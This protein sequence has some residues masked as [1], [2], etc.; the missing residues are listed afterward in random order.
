MLRDEHP[1]GEKFFE[2]KPRLVPMKEQDPEALPEFPRLRGPLDDLIRGI[3]GD[4]AYEHKA[5]TALTCFGLKISG[6]CRLASDPYLQPRFYACLIGPVG[7]GKSSGEAHVRNK[8]A[9]VLEDVQME[10]SIDSGPALVEALTEHPRLLY[11]PDEIADALGKGKSRPLASNSLHGEF[12]RLYENNTTGRRVLKKNAEQTSITNAQ[13]AIIGSATPERFETM[14]TGSAGASGGLQSRFVVSYSEQPLPKMSTPDRESIVEVAIHALKGNLEGGWLNV[15][16][17]GDAQD[18]L[19]GSKIDFTENPRALHMGKRFAWILAV[20]ERRLEI[21]GDLMERG[22]QFA[23][24][25]LAVHQKFMPKDAASW[26]QAFENRI[27]CYYQRHPG[28]SERD[29]RRSIKPDRY[30]G[31]HDTWSRAFAALIRCGKLIATGQNQYKKNLW[32]LD[33]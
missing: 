4:Y 26:T 20:S 23:S 29:C 2:G 27:I 17:S 1:L 9:P 12:L 21:D 28:T 18:I 5:L 11:A 6:N 25:Q 30:P 33:D 32:S 10:Y 14:W 7:T 19:L 8:L 15:R 31:G 16:M 3:T 22:L 24:Y 13:F